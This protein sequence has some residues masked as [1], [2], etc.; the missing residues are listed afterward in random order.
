MHRVLVAE[1]PKF[2]A[3]DRVSIPFFAM[4]D[5]G[6]LIQCLIGQNKHP[7]VTMRDWLKKKIDAAFKERQI[8]LNV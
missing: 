4:P 1:D 5:Q 3:K 7:P 2:Q 6:T 8:Q